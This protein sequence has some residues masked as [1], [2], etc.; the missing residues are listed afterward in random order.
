MRFLWTFLA[1]VVV[2]AVTAAEPG[3]Q[4]KLLATLNGARPMAY[5]PIAFSPDGKV[6]AWGDHVEGDLTEEGKK[7]NV[8][9]SGS[10]KLWDVGK[11]KVIATLRDAAGDCDYS[12][13]GVVFSPDG[14]TLAAVCDGK[15]KLWDVA[16][17]REKAPLKRDSKWRGFPAFSRDGKIIA[18]ASGDE[19]TVILWD[20][21][22]RKEKVSLKGFSRV[23]QVD[24]VQP[25]RQA[26]RRGGRGIFDDRSAGGR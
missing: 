1:V 26:L 13:D 15:V 19:T 7:E 5:A 2:P 17:G 12:V 16:T 9:I 20:S 6:L 4:L 23:G 3:P 11:R 21:S 24:G 14:K 10:V 18:S 22:T 25:R 8:P